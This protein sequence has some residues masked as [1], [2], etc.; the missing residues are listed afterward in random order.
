MKYIK[1]VRY[2]IFVPNFFFVTQE[3]LVRQIQNR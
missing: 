3:D 1:F 2:V